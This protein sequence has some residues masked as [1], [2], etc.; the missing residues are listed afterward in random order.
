MTFCNKLPAFLTN[1]TSLL[2]TA[3]KSKN[4]CLYNLLIDYRGTAPCIL[5]KRRY[6]NLINIIISTACN[7]AKNKQTNKSKSKR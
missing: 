3:A 5:W 4:I 6:I 7:N 2:A 1:S